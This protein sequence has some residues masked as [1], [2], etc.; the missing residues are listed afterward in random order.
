M[1]SRFSFAV[2][3]PVSEAGVRGGDG[4]FEYGGGVAFEFG[5]RLADD[6]FVG[7]TVSFRS[8]D[9]RLLAGIRFEDFT[10]VSK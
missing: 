4:F 2:A 6:S 3:L 10:R 7:A 5:G 8:G 9:G 1:V